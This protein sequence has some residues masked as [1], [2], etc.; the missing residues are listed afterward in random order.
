MAANPET[1]PTV[2]PTPDKLKVVKELTR[3]E[4]VFALARDAGD[5]AGLLRRLRLQGLR[6]RPGRRR[7]PSR[8]SWAATRATSPAWR[9][10]ARPLVSGGYDGRLIWWDL[11]SGSQVRTVEAH[12]KWIR[13]VA[14]TPDGTIVASVADDMVCRLWDAET[15][16]AASTSCAATR[17]RRRITSPRCSTPAPS[18]PTAVTWRPA[19]R[20]ATSSS[21]TSTTGR[22]AA[23]LEAPGHV[24]LGP[25]PAP[26]F[27]RRHPRRWPSRPTA[28]RLAVGGIGKIGNIDHLDGQARVEVFDWRKGER[29]HEF[30]GDR[31]KG[32][33]ERLVFL[34]DG[35]RLLAVGG[36]NDG[37]LL[38][39]STSKAK[40]VLVQEKA[41][42]HVHDAAFGDTPETLFTAAHGKLA[43]Y[44]LKG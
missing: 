35:D 2:T 43:V 21:G 14:A 36:A 30:P 24:H 7:S 23:T 12:A 9:W 41:P 10:P 5:A 26:A 25:G 15:G 1:P 16:H 40:S 28:T 19:T 3:N 27:D 4:I 6:R 42:T 13:D 33:V 34:P 22:P 39:R 18:R 31:P 44:E 17:R 38:A 32:L 29:T 37:F 8:R 11:E 20:S